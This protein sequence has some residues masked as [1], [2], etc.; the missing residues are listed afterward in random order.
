M[1]HN[2]ARLAEVLGYRG[3]TTPFLDAMRAA[4]A[5]LTGKAILLGLDP[6]SAVRARREFSALLKAL[7]K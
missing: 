5:T 3:L 4:P 2:L 7:R 1:T 6:A